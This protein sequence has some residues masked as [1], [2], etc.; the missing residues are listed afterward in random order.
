MSIPT[1]AVTHAAPKVL[2]RPAVTTQDD[3][4]SLIAKLRREE[5]LYPRDTELRAKLTQVIEQFWI[6]KDLSQPL[7]AGNRD[8]QDVLIV[9]GPTGAGK[10]YSTQTA[11]ESLQRSFCLPGDKL[12]DRC[13]YIKFPGSFSTLELAIRILAKLAVDIDPKRLPNEWAM[14][15]A[16]HGALEAQEILA[17]QFDEFQRYA[18]VKTNSKSGKDDE[19]RRLAEKI[20]DLLT[21][22]WPVAL[23]ISGMPETLDFFTLEAMEQVGRR[24]HEVVFNPMTGAEARTLNQALARYCKIANVALDLPPDY[25]VVGRLAK[26]SFNTLGRSLELAQEAVVNAVR[27]RS[28]TLEKQD[29][30]AMFYEHW[31]VRS[32]KN[33]FHSDA[34]HTMPHKPPKNTLD[35]IAKLQE[36]K[37]KA[38]REAK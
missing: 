19:A 26:T 35:D 25:N 2:K 22:H 34:W 31:D 28:A 29:F 7:I 23:I 17:V 33:L 27:R 4:S 20:N 13:L 36:D 18:T 16:V 32:E 21:G 6:P 38:S 24:K 5:I 3:L 12:E 30:V 8:E 9:T 14:W 11:L 15:A 10:T 1:T 37:R